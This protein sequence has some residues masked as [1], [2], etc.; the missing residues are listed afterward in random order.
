M[1]H[2]L[3]FNERLNP[4]DLDTLEKMLVEAGTADELGKAR[5]GSGLGLSVRSM[6]EARSRS[7]KTCLRWVSRRQ[8]P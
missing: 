3:R 5:S 4:A 6:G 2:K 8:D 7:G 1:I